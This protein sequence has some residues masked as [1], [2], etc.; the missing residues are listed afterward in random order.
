M[1]L[2]GHEGA[3]SVDVHPQQ[4]VGAA[5]GYRTSAGK[6]WHHRPPKLRQDG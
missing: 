6:Y 4:G 3:I 2:T 1:Y 5:R